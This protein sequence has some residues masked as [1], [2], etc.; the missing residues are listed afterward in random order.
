M[1]VFSLLRQ[2]EKDL[3]RYLL[4][5]ADVA[6]AEIRLGTPQ[7]KGIP[8]GSIFPTLGIGA[9]GTEAGVAGIVGKCGEHGD[10]SPLL[11]GGGDLC[12]IDAGVG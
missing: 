11:I 12:M 1:Q 10:S 9:L 2:L 4:I 6:S 7:T 8:S 5:S 3:G